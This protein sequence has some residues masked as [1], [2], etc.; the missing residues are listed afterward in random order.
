MHK[1][2]VCENKS[3]DFARSQKMFARLHDRET[4]TFRNSATLLQS[5]YTTAVPL[6]YP[7][8]VSGE[9]HTAQES[10]PKHCTALL[11]PAL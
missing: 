9:I 5:H 10:L 3:Q 2:L 1:F 7:T 8:V 11:C 4:V 6:K